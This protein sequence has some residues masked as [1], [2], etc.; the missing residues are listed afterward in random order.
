[1]LIFICSIAVILLETDAAH[2]YKDP[3]QYTT[4]FRS[5]FIFMV[6]VILFVLI[7][8]MCI[9]LNIIK[10]LVISHQRRVTNSFMK[11]GSSKEETCP[12]SLKNEVDTIVQMV[13]LSYLMQIKILL[14]DFFNVENLIA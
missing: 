5:I 3:T 12:S 2:F 10:T 6:I 4:V 11:I 13:S 1:M 7:S 8:N 14:Y 9:F